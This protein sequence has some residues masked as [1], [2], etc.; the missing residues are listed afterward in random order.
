MFE[1][2]NGRLAQILCTHHFN[3]AADLQTTLHCYVW[4]YNEHLP[5]NALH[6]RTPSRPSKP[7]TQHTST[8]FSN[9]YVIVW[10]STPTLMNPPDLTTKCQADCTPLL[11]SD[12]KVAVLQSFRTVDVPPWITRCMDSVRQWAL[13]Q[14]W[15]YLILDDR[16]LDLP[17]AWVRKRCASNLYAVTDVARLIWAEDVLSGNHERVIWVD[18]DMLVFDPSGLA[19]HVDEVHEHGFARELFLY[20]S[21]RRIKPQWGLNNTLMVFDR[22]APV[23]ADYLRICLERLEGYRDGEVPRTAMGPMLLQHLDAAEHLHR[24]EGVGLFTPAMLE[25]F[26]A[27]RDALMHQYLSYCAL[28]PAAANLCHFMRNATTASRRP[29]FDCMYTAAIER[30]MHQGLVCDARRGGAIQ[31]P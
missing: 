25:P 18:A 16:F 1:R 20:V 22:H 26:A 29:A 23:L 2:F 4:L 6:H 5:Q 30:L 9:Q 14:G 28:L 19:R 27:G 21:G 17:P 13:S 10:N 12:K 8:C 11:H 31:R 15:D 24:I 7:E 3:S